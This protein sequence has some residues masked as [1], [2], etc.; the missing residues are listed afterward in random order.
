[1]KIRRQELRELQEA[2]AFEWGTEYGMESTVADSKASW[3]EA[4][5]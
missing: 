2:D 1:M 4:D 3:Y 5:E